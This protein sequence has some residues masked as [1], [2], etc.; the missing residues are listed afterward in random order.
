MKENICM[1]NNSPLY[2]TVFYNIFQFS[3]AENILGDY[4]RIK[5]S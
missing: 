4:F 2:K 3:A 5:M 1:S